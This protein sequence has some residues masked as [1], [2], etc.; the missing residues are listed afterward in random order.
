MAA[1]TGTVWLAQVNRDDVLGIFTSPGK[2]RQACQ[3]QANEYF[4]PARTPALTWSGSDETVQLASYYH[5]GEGLNQ[6]FITT[7]Y[8]LDKDASS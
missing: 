1:G 8:E 5:P 6:V 2:A 4:G 3:D 7:P